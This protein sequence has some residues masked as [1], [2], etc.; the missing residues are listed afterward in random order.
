ME[1]M[2]SAYPD[3]SELRAKRDVISSSPGQPGDRV[4]LLSEEFGVA[5]RQSHEVGFLPAGERR[6]FQRQKK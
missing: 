5:F 6:N 3:L 1:N 4:R 2:V